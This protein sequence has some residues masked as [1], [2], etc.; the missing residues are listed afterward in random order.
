MCATVGKDGRAAVVELRSGKKKKKGA[1]VEADA[2]SF[3]QRH[4]RQ[5]STCWRRGLV[6]QRRRGGCIFIRPGAFRI[7]EH[8]LAT[9]VSLP[10][11]PGQMQIHSAKSISDNGALVG[12]EG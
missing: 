8:L 1:R 12:D 7:I 5:W 9:R 6:Y 2:Y 11:L 3:D 10:A 4:F